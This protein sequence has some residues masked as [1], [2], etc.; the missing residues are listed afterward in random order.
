MKVSYY[1]ADSAI[2][3]KFSLK[4]CVAGTLSARIVRVIEPSVFIHDSTGIRIGSVVFYYVA[5]LRVE[6]VLI[7]CID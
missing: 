2:A 5:R 4:Y 7:T 3:R 1:T 6:A